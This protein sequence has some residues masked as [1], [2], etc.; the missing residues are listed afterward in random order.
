MSWT[1]DPITDFEAYDRQQAAKLD[2]LPKC[3]ECGEP[4]QD[5]TYYEIEGKNYC[6]KCLEDFEKWT[7]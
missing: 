2:K 3:D 4:I 1:D 6:L 5:E 7:V